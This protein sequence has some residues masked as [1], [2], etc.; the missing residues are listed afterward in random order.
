MWGAKVLLISKRK[1]IMFGGD[2]WPKG[3]VYNSYLVPNT[4]IYIKKKHLQN[5]SP[6]YKSNNIQ[7]GKII[8]ADNFYEEPKLHSRTEE[9]VNDF[10]RQLKIK[11]AKAQDKYGYTDNWR[12]ATANANGDG[13]RDELKEHFY[14]GDPLDVAAYCAFLWYLKEPTYLEP[15]DDGSY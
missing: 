5:P 10:S 9:L 2:Q 4:V 3:P 8:T 1:D 7:V 14:K 6:T 13:L 12:T 15:S 11:L